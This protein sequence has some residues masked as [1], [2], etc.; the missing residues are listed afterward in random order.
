MCGS[1]GQPI[2]YSK[3]AEQS[4]CEYAV[5][6]ILDH[7]L[8]FELIPCCGQ[9]PKAVTSKSNALS[10]APTQLCNMSYA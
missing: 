2:A 9:L 5:T 7:Q 1:A 8:G 6:I 10:K 4:V 3:S